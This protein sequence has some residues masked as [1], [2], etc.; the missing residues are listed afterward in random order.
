MVSY[1]ACKAYAQCSSIH[2]R[3]LMQLFVK[4]QDC[5]IHVL[6]LS[7]RVADVTSLSIAEVIEP[8]GQMHSTGRVARPGTGVQYNR[9][10]AT[11]CEAGTAGEGGKDS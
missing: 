7:S 3:G 8:T 5:R 9:A 2:L 10:I 11:R 6:V 4:T 1:V